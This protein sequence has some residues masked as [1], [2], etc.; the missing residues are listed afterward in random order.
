MQGHPDL[1]FQQSL[2]V[3]LQPLFGA[4]FMF[5]ISQKYSRFKVKPFAFPKKLDIWKSEIRNERDFIEFLLRNEWI[6][7]QIGIRMKSSNGLFPDIK[8]HIFSGNQ[9]PINVEV[10]YWAENYKQH[11]H[12]FAGCDL[13]LSFLRLPKTKV[14][15]GCP[16]WSFYSGAQKSR[17]FSY[18]LRDDIGYDFKDSS[19]IESP[20]YKPPQDNKLF[21]DGK[22]WKALPG[23]GER[24]TGLFT[25]QDGVVWQVKRI[26]DGY[27]WIE[28][29]RTLKTKA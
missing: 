12:P 19:E 1:L 13:I 2:W 18:C 27:K 4:F 24:R 15:K 11:E 8:G 3:V 10:E 29:S 25:D 28:E 20:Y 7:H 5:G 23:I 22:S 21:F 17:V 26:F 9:E 16:V 14:V 6:Q